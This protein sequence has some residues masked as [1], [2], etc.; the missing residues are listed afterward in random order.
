MLYYQSASIVLI[1]RNV[2]FENCC[3]NRTYF[4]SKPIL[5]L[6]CEFLQSH[7][8]TLLDSENLNN[9]TFQSIIVRNN[10]A[11]FLTSESSLKTV[12]KITGHNY[13]LD[14][15]VNIIRYHGFSHFEFE[16]LFSNTT[17]YFTNNTCNNEMGAVDSPV[18]FAQ[19]KVLFE[20]SHAVFSNNRGH[21][22]GVISTK[23]GEG[24]KIVFSDNTT[25]IFCNN[26]GKKEG[27]FS[28]I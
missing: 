26:V 21:T 12:I 11:P 6:H 15:K 14:N 13:F 7:D 10:T 23:H 25:L 4:G 24:T 2:I 16:L 9:F 17:L 20:H 5:D 1:I 3:N 22:G 27:Y 19:A 8:D 28:W 18:Y